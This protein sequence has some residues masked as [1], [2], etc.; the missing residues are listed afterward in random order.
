MK[1]AFHCLSLFLIFIILANI[2]LFRNVELVVAAST[3]IQINDY[4]N[5]VNEVGTNFNNNALTIWIGSS[6]ASSYTGLRFTNVSIPRGA[7]ITSAYIELRSSLNQ[8]VNIRYEIAA[9]N[10]GNSASFSSLSRPSQRN[11]TVAR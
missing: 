3:S 7:T 10:S 6:G 1:K 2:T 5:D 8:T 4:R 9:E 11:L